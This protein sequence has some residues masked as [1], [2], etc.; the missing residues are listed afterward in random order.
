ML[1]TIVAY[2]WII[3]D[4][5]RPIDTIILWLHMFR[6]N[7]TDITPDR[8]D[9]NVKWLFF[10]ASLRGA[11]VGNSNLEWAV[12][13]MPDIFQYGC[14]LK[15]SG[16]Q[17]FKNRD[18]YPTFVWPCLL[19][20]SADISVGMYFRSTAMINWIEE[21]LDCYFYLNIIPSGSLEFRI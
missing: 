13:L 1:S 4:H 6:F 14:I 16:V 8:F 21:F 12:S 19:E 17:P 5:F 18:F 15:S 2:K 11:R 3:R 10:D 9:Y 20:I 7:D